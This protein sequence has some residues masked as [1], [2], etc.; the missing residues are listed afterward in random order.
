MGHTDVVPVTAAGWR[1]DPFGG[2]IIDGPDGPEVWGRGAVDMLNI[3]ASM[4][5]AFRHLAERGFRPTGDLIYFG[6]ADEEA[7]SA[8]GARW[9]ADHHAD[10][11]P[12]RQRADR[13]RRPA[14]RAERGAVHRRQ[15]RREGRGVAAPAGAR[16]A[17]ARVGAVPARQRARQ[18]GR[19]DPTAARLPAGAAVPRTLAAEGRGARTRPATSS[20]SL[21]DPHLIDDALDALP[22][23]AAASHF[24]A[25]THTTFSPN[26]IDG[27][28]VGRRPDEG[29]RDPRRRRDR[30]RRPHAAGGGTRRRP[31]APP[32]GAR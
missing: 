12:R 31:G 5:V 8:Y 28:G 2:E 3:T 1:E 14:Q 16:H 30:R 24:H 26:V 9:M 19:G 29:Q 32:G 11:D 13:E 27:S 7:G 22:N 18:G 10:A 21:L 6:V 15:R 20:A 23:A 25:C 17:G 4:A